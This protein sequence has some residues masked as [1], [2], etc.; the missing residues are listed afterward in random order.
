MKC[1]T[2]FGLIPRGLVPALQMEPS[3]EGTYVALDTSAQPL[4]DVFNAAVG[5]VRLLMY[6]SPTCGQ[7]LRG[8]RKA[9]NREEEARLTLGQGGARKEG[10]T[11]SSATVG[12][13]PLARGA[14]AV[15]YLGRPLP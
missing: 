9:Q 7:C 6:V 8:A 3:Q 13:R 2:P 14:R 1:S 4:K 12:I 10:Q 5:K 11:T 15:Q